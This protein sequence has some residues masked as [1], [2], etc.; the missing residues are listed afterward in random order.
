LGFFVQTPIEHN[1]ILFEGLLYPK[2]LPQAPAFLST[3]VTPRSSPTKG[4]S[5]NS[6]CLTIMQVD[7]SPQ[8]TDFY[9]G[10]GALEFSR[11]AVAV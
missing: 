8:S 2:S 6:F 7:N 9:K 1:W 5:D 4:Y 3:T 11:L 10:L